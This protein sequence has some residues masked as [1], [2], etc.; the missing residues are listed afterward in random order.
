MF[1]I[2]KPFQKIL[3]IKNLDTLV[4]K[5]FLYVRKIY[6]CKYLGG[7]MYDYLRMFSTI[8]FNT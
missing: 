8:K 3:K 6:L 1:F 5:K 2:N 4:K 7:F